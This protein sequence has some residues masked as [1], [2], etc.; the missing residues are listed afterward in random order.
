MSHDIIGA[1]DRETQLPTLPGL[2]ESLLRKY[3]LIGNRLILS[4]SDLRNEV[5]STM[6]IE[7]LIPLST[8][9]RLAKLLSE[10]DFLLAS[11]EY[12]SDIN[13]IYKQIFRESAS[14]AVREND[15]LWLHRSSGEQ[16]S[17]SGS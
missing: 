12:K 10:A 7:L 16:S 1:D 17:R 4:S 8:H 2:S 5:G 3:L 15:R 14:F 9:K 6:V 11:N 13:K